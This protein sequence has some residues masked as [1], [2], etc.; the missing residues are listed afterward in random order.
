[1]AYEYRGKLKGSA[2][3]WQQPSKPRR[4]EPKPVR[5]PQP[6]KPCGT[7]AAYVRHRARGEQPC[8]ECTTAR[9]EYVASQRRT[10]PEARRKPRAK[11]GT[12]SGAVRHY[13]LKEKLCEPCAQA[14]RDYLN[15]HRQE[16]REREA[17]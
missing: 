10:D 17:A 15:R 12:Y 2:D 11:C 3:P 6:L 16:L 7:N 8:D 13:R 1:M 14:R 5:E 9:R 4:E